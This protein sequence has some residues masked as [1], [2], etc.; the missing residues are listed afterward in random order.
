MKD[1]KDFIQELKDAPQKRVV[2]EETGELAD[3]RNFDLKDPEVLVK[4]VGR[5]RLSQLKKHAIEH[6]KNVIKVAERGDDFK[7]VQTMLDPN[8]AA[9]Q[10]VGAIVDVEKELISPLIKRRITIRKKQKELSEVSPPDKKIEK[11]ILKNKERFQKEYGK[12]KGTEIVYAKAW[13]MYNEQKNL[14]EEELIKLPLGLN[15]A[16]AKAEADKFSKIF[17]KGNSLV[18]IVDLLVSKYGLNGERI[19]D[20]LTKK[21]IDKNVPLAKQYILKMLSSPSMVKKLHSFKGY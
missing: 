11:W 5:M 21:K 14:K 6:L 4:G 3:K 8:S 20:E 13:K 19:W 9:I 17:L 12:K 1:I 16:I 15:K 10:Y 2:S 7:I 18:D